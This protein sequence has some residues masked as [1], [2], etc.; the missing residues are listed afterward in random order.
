MKREI[1]S[2]R[3]DGAMK[4]EPT[5]NAQADACC[6]IGIKM[7]FIVGCSSLSRQPALGR[8]RM[9]TSFLFLLSAIIASVRTDCLF[10]FI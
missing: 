6:I 7:K 8:Y 9:E 4:K 2:E 10:Y 5:E 3:G 1:T